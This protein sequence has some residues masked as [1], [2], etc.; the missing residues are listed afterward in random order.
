MIIITSGIID[1]PPKLFNKYLKE[2]LINFIGRKRDYSLWAY[3]NAIS[4][5]S[6][7][8]DSYSSIRFL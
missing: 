2:M 1:R 4:I 6:L 3:L 8:R 5:K 7:V